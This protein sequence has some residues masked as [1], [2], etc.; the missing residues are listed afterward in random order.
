MA[1]FSPNRL[2]SS[3]GALVG[4]LQSAGT[5]TSFAS[6]PNAGSERALANALAA[7]ARAQPLWRAFQIATI[8]GARAAEHGFASAFLE[9]GFIAAGGGL[10]LSLRDRG[11]EL[12]P[13]SDSE[14]SDAG[15]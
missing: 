4:Y 1:C 15:G 9:A 10:L 14:L 7:W 8:D 2:A 11:P 13:E 12:E 5:L 3:L 6:E